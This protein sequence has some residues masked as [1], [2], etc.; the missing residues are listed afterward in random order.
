[1]APPIHVDVSVTKDGEVA[2]L[3]MSGTQNRINTMFCKKWLKAL[4]KVE[5]WPEV[6]ALVTTGSG[7]FY[8]NGLDLENLMTFTEAEGTEFGKLFLELRRRI[9]CFPMVTVAAINGHCFA[10]GMLIAFLHDYRVM[11]DGRGWMCLNEIDLGMVF[12]PSLKAIIT[13]KFTPVMIRE[14]TIFGNRFTGPQALKL[15]FIDKLADNGKSVQVAIDLAQSLTAGR[16]YG[17][18]IVH[19]MKEDFYGH[20]VFDDMAELE[21]LKPKL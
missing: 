14:A 5:S 3:T 2:I 17:R 4:D 7:K 10:G 18:Q 13:T 6:K 16:S 1:M 20:I 8:S 19:D 12:T 21:K 15:G 11:H 9:L